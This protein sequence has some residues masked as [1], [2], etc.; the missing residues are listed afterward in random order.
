M[1]MNS[2]SGRK[3]QGGFFAAGLGLALFAVFAAA[4]WG[5][6]TVAEGQQTAAERVVHA[7][8]AERF[9]ADLVTFC[10]RL[11]RDTIPGR[12]RVHD[13]AKASI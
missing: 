11:V 5:V 1:K 3:S 9:A 10:G 12:V 2:I 7:A 13:F 4:G 6:V 8:A